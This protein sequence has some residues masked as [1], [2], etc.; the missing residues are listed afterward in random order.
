MGALPI[1]TWAVV[2]AVIGAAVFGTLYILAS[3][4]R[5]AT[6]RVELY[7]R[8]A[9][10]RADYARQMAERVGADHHELLLSQ[11]DLLD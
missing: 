2:A 8:V 1:E 7:K 11:D 3:I 9:D 6:R 5:D 4:L 10:L